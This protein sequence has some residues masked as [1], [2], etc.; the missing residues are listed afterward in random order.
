VRLEVE[1]RLWKPMVENA[2]E[3]E[4][5][6]PQDMPKGDYE[7]YLNLPDPEEKL[8]ANPAYS[9]RLANKNVWEENTGYNKLGVVVQVAPEY[10]TGNYSGTLVFKK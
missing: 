6:I 2:I 5:G 1:P 3:A 9:V 7:L 4:V 8:Y 10:K